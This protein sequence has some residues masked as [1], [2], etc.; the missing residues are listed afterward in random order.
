MKEFAEN[1]GRQDE[2]G[3]SD[4]H[5]R[6]FLTVGTQPHLSNIDIVV[7]ILG[8]LQPAPRKLLGQLANTLK[9]GQEFWSQGAVPDSPRA[10]DP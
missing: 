8:T 4:K 6:D 7:A 2:T 5:S 9:F 3:P 1:R 10:C